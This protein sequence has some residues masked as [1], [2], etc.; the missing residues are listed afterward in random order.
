MVSINRLR[1]DLHYRKHW[2][3]NKKKHM[4]T[5]YTFNIPGVVIWTFH[6]GV[7]LLAVYYG[8]KMLTQTVTSNEQRGIGLVLIGLGVLM[9]FYHMHLWYYYSHHRD[10]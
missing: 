6:I 9:L 4:T 1:I 5:A 7:G 2:L 3:Q 8:Y 10:S